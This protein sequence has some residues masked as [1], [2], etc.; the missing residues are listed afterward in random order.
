WDNYRDHP[1]GL[2]TI[3]AITG[4]EASTIEDFYEPFLLQIG[5]IER[6]PRGRIVTRRAVEHLQQLGEI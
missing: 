5:F 1:V 6:T 3:A 4:D 2:N